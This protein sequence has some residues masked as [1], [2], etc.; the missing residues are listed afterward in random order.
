[1]GL[2][3]RTRYTDKKKRENEMTIKL[4]RDETNE[5][6]KKNKTILAYMSSLNVLL[7]RK[8]EMSCWESG[9]ISIDVNKFS[10]FSQ[11]AQFPYP[12]HTNRMNKMPKNENDEENAESSFSPFSSSSSS[13]SSLVGYQVFVTGV[14]THNRA[15]FNFIF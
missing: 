3:E 1:M 6:S 9:K 4:E 7:H 12:F 15:K 14:H 13:A 2:V 8:P 11:N 5:R 10:T